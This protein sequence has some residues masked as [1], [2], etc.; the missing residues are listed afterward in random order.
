MSRASGRRTAIGTAYR[1]RLRRRLAALLTSVVA[2]AGL[3][4]G[5]T[6]TAAA[7]PLGSAPIVPHDKSIP[8]TPVSSHYQAPAAMPVWHPSVVA[9]PSGTATLSLSAT[10]A[11]NSAHPV[12]ALVQ[13]G[14]LPVWLAPTA[15]RP[16]AASNS[17]TERVAVLPRSTA[18]GLGVNG[19]VVSVQRTDTAPGG[20]SARVTVNYTG[21]Q[22]A[23]GGDWA[24]RLRLVRLP[25][26]ALTTPTKP[27]CRTQTPLDSTLDGHTDTVSANVALA[28]QTTTAAAPLVIAATSTP[29]GG[30]GDFTATSLKPSGSWQAGGSADAFS[31]SYPIQVPPVP[32]G[33]EPTVA[34][35]YDSQA[36]D[37]L[38]SSTNNQPS[39]LGDGWDYSPGFVE[40]SYQSCS[41]N[42]AGPT[43]TGDNCWSTN[44]TLTL[45]LGG[46]TSILV[47][48]DASHTY[49]PQDDSNERVQYL[50]NATNPTNGAQNG[51]YF[52]VTTT[53]GT[54]YFFGLN[55]LPGWASGNP[56]TNS[57]W[58]EPVYATAAGQPCYNA[59]FTSSW[60][61]QAYR[62]NLDYVVDTHAD[63]VSYFYNTET[64]SYA[65]DLDTTATATYTRGGYLARIQYGQRAGQVYATQPAAQ[66][67]F[68]S[69]GRCNQASCDPSTLSTSTAS[70]WPDVPEDLACTTGSACAATSPGFWTDY[71]LSTIQTQALY[72][73]TETNVDSWAL[74]HSFPDTGDGTQPVLWLSSITHTGQDPNAIGSPTA[75]PPAATSSP[76]TLPPVVFTSRPLSNRVLANGYLP[77]TRQRLVKITTE[78]GETIAVNYSAPGCGTGVPSDP[79]QN[80]SLC[81]PDYWTPPGQ[82]APILD[83]FNKFIVTGV[84]ETDPT[85]GNGTISTG[86][87]DTIGTTYTP[88][89]APGWHYNDNPAT[90]TNQRTWDQWRGYSGMIVSTGTAPDPITQTQYTYFRGMNGDTL[91]GG[92]TRSVSITDSRGDP[93]VPDDN[94]N[95]GEPYET[96]VDNGSAVVTDTISDPWSRQTGS[97]SLTGLPTQLSFL[98][99]TA[100][101]RVYTPLASGSTRETETAYTHD[102][103]G[104][105]TQTND[106]G[107]VSTPLDDLCTTTSYADNTGAWILDAVDETSVMSVN[108][109]TTPTYPTNAVSD[110]R[111]FYDST[112]TLDTAP[113]VGD[114]TMTQQATS[115][116]GDG[117][118]NLITTATSAVDQYGRALT[119]TNGDGKTTT[120]AYTPATGA[121][122]TSI[123][124]TDPMHFLT[125]TTYDPLRDLPQSKKDPAKFVSSQ[126]YDALGRLT[127]VNSV[128]IPAANTFTYTVS[129]T[130][131]SVVD[132]N[133]LNV[134]GT[135]RTS[136]TLYD[137]MLRARE[138]QTQTPDNGR[139]IT[140]TIY[141]TDGWVSETTDPYFNANPVAATYVQAQAGDV[142][143]ETGFTYD[144]AGRKTA[145]LAYARANLTWQTTYTYGGNFTTTVPPAGGTAT[146]TLT[147]A[148]GHTTDLY[149][150]HT[151]VPTDAVN[152]PPAD[153][154][155][156][157][158]TYTPI[159]KQAT[160]ADAAGN[161]WSYQY[162][163]LGQQTTAQD[164]DTGTTTTVY[165]NAGLVSSVTDA[166]G[167]Q[168]TTTYDNDAR[169]TAQ[170]D[171]TGNVATSAS[172]KIAAWTYD[173]ASIS[174]G[175]SKAVGYPASSSVINGG[176]T[177]T[178]TVLAYNGYAKLQGT[179]TTLTGTDAA[180]LPAGGVT[181]SY[182]YSSTGYA[183]GHTDPG[184]DGLPGETLTEGLDPFGQV[185]SLGSNINSYVT[186]VGYTELGQPLEYTLPA[187][188]GNVWITMQYDQQTQALTD[189]KANDAN[190]STV[191]D[192]TSYAY[193]GTNVS[194]GAGLV[195]S[196]T[197]NQNAGAVVDTQCFTYDYAQRLNTAWTATDHCATTP[198]A[199][200]SSVGGPAPY[201]Q[202]WTYDP[203]GDRA[204]Q[205]DHDTAGN[206]AND[207]TTS[208]VYPTAGSATDQ[209]H[210]LTSTTAT[211]PN[212]ATNTA[213]YT[214][215]ASGN[216]TG[217]T[218]GAT[219]NQT[220]TWN[221]QNQLATD[222]TTNG[223]TSYVYDASG[224]LIIRRDPSQTTLFL[225][226]DQLVLNTATGATSGTRTYT[227]GSTAI[228]SLSSQ[229]GSNP[230]YLVPDRQGTDQLTIDSATYHV[231]RRQYLPFGS[232]RG[233]PPATWPGGDKGYIGGTPDPTTTL[234]NLG[235]REYNPANGRFLSADPVLEGT[236]PTQMGG[237][238]YAGN[239]PTTSSDSTGLMRDGGGQCGIMAGDP[240]NSSEGSAAPS[241]PSAAP[242]IKTYPGGGGT[243]LTVAN[244]GA[245]INGVLLPGFVS[246][247][248]TVA[249]GVSHTISDPR[250]H[251][252]RSDLLGST[253]QAIVFWCEWGGGQYCNTSSDLYLWALAVST[254]DTMTEGPLGV[255]RLGGHRPSGAELAEAGRAFAAMEQAPGS[256]RDAA[257]ATM[258]DFASCA[259]SFAGHTPVLMANG[260]SKPID[261]V[262]VGDTVANAI[263]GAFPGLPD[264]HH[265]VTAVH[266]SYTDHDFTDVTITSSN[267]PATITGTAHHLY[268]DV[269]THT[270]TEAHNLRIG[271]QLQTSNGVSVRIAGL[272]DY[273]AIMVTYNLTI[274]NLHAYY[275]EA[276]D[277]PVLV[278]NS[279]CDQAKALAQAF[280]A[281]PPG[282]AVGGDRNVAAAVWEID[283]QSGAGVSVSGAAPRPGTIGMPANPV[284][285][286]TRAADSEWKI[287]E[288]VASQISPDSQG[289]VNIYSELTICDSCRSVIQQFQQAFPGVVV[290][291]SSG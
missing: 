269:T 53:D 147:D 103:D 88:V 259:N 247:P 185:T 142:P 36:V 170:Y 250:Y 131:P 146:T 70:N 261:Q 120:T 155:D 235:A 151:G 35:S 282:G 171:T 50:T 65:A 2:T 127:Q 276:Q 255:G 238:D 15:A 144:G 38:T 226:D 248:E 85:G 210:T 86:G 160:V 213:S 101:T 62:W 109:T 218:S 74:A 20:A 237:Y 156:T 181:T 201:W 169:K 89:G 72:G 21:F 130:G 126:Q 44:N 278:H 180:L 104:R 59:T 167:K 33:L 231:T 233:A 168:T 249:Q 221:D 256:V 262:K 265:T 186:A 115:Y 57:V 203:A 17:S 284:F 242:V 27:A 78:T 45:S 182:T 48:D 291:T 37:G 54:Q 71:T 108:C 12:D 8:V 23:F 148:R 29:S 193:N 254:G 177:Y 77:I 125:T 96:V 39:W 6:P 268:W 209:P 286:H 184:I 267:G 240:C 118:P 202:S 13:A 91:P 114:A 134:D 84:T 19:V 192:D 149:Q 7:A 236:D 93:A 290:N 49:H 119:S 90:P 162:D 87:S 232:P 99:G 26:C 266:V 123:A 3:V 172:N 229:P 272:L 150:Y 280:R 166:R 277:T 80:T 164:P 199:G 263:P 58:T 241:T 83:W 117:T 288:H 41:Q 145:A 73:T 205:T 224:S 107:D 135:Y 208:Y 279:S 69:A 283:G 76:I 239:N 137:S 174:F 139:N 191:V 159:G 257:A 122:P 112:T 227:A 275:V 124:V 195:T 67:V 128:G 152:D 116:N 61:Q 176:D 110:T 82:T 1:Q 173:T 40:R 111:T 200:S 16:A 31:W 47:W 289:V 4:A 187:S 28:G 75:T 14:S 220:L 245:R 258:N 105:V 274:D 42:P 25:G 81:F 194:P 204:T 161:T 198:T 260:S 281:N 94:Q 197:D 175:S 264:Q 63:V 79:S 113:T 98:T 133:T 5:L 207:T 178:Q 24:A 68:T 56:T 43:K 129:N 251:F 34:L 60:C 121:E 22:H 211:G 217:I 163:L 55:Q 51:E 285:I 206:T 212:L 154:S 190:S 252:D 253:A 222:T 97:H 95:A 270:W 165:D 64:N 18:T 106:L 140:D 52:V 183:N 188:A 246:S 30:G 157:R 100:D 92:G 219:G 215:D 136:E 153:Y 223:T 143:S 9:W 230:V 244:G 214:Y 141:N 10:A 158:Y 179:R 11:G 271:D 228:A 225:G 196:T 138:T 189:V 132:T 273:A 102:T 32:G 216:T 287:L 46:R 66:V 243:T 234:E